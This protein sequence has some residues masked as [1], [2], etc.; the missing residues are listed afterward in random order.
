VNR[1]SEEIIQL[2]CD[3]L[4]ENLDQR[5]SIAFPCPSRRWY[6]DDV[7]LYHVDLIG[8]NVY[9]GINNNFFNVGSNGVLRY[10]L[11]EPPPLYMFQDG[12][13]LMA[14]E[15]SELAFPEYAPAGVSNVTVV[16]DV[17]EALTGRWRCELE[18]VVGA[19]IAETIVTEC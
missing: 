4:G 11:V 16:D 13:L 5:T 7:L 8:Q 10:G 15:A 2:S 9:K 3:V 19:Y 6:K 12:E 1:S 14:F 17:F 18:N